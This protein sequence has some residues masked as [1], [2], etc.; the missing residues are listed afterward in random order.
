[1]TACLPKFRKVIEIRTSFDVY[2]SKYTITIRTLDLVVLLIVFIV[3]LW[4]R[5]NS[6]NLYINNLKTTIKNLF[7]INTIVCVH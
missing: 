5:L 7:L 3:L 4:R 1:M 6:F 2:D